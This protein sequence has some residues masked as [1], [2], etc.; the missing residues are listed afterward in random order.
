MIPKRSSS[1]EIISSQVSLVQTFLLAKI[2]LKDYLEVEANKKPSEPR[3]TRIKLITQI[4]PF[5]NADG[6][7][8]RNPLNLLNPWFRHYSLAQINYKDYL[9]VEAK[10]KK[11]NEM[12]NRRRRW[13]RYLVF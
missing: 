7:N 2:D 5:A 3:I 10:I 6:F 13:K 12:R 8:P 11:I 4:Y 9:E 1:W